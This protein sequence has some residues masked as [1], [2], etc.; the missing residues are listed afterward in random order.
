MVRCSTRHRRR[1]LDDV[2][3]VHLAAQLL[4]LGILFQLAALVKLLHVAN[5]P[6]PAGQKIGIERQNHFGAFRPIYRV[7]VAS[8]C[9]FSAFARAVADRGFPLMPLHL[10]ILF[11]QRLQLLA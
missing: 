5:V 7:D 1:R 8:K 6:R 11:Q 2:Q 10:R 3:A 9:E 4:Y